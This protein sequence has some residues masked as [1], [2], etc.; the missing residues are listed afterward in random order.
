MKSPYEKNIKVDVYDRSQT[1]PKR[2]STTLN[3]A[4]CSFLFDE[5]NPDKPKFRDNAEARK[6]LE[7]QAQNWVN[8]LTSS[9]TPTS[10]WLEYLL[11]R[12]VHTT[13][14]NQA[15]AIYTSDNLQLNV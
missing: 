10:Q 9:V 11:I 14:F 1:P 15:R 6:W 7:Q 3:Y 13:G 2:T 4:V 12:E 5:L 8:S